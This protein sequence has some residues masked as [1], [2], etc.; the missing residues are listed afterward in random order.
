[1]PRKFPDT[2]ASSLVNGLPTRYILPY[3]SALILDGNAISVQADTARR[4][5][6][7][8]GPPVGAADAIFS[9]DPNTGVMAI[10]IECS[11][12]QARYRMK[13]S[14]MRG[15]RGAEVR[16][17][18]CG[19]TIAVLTPGTTSRA[20]VA[21]VPGGQSEGPRSHPLTEKDHSLVEQQ[22]PSSGRARKG[23]AAG[24]G[25]TQ[26]HTALAEETDATE[27]VPDNVY[28]LELVRGGRPKR[29]PTGGYDISGS[30]R[31]DPPT[32]ATARESA[33]RSPSVAEPLEELEGSKRLIL[34]EEPIHGQREGIASAP[35]KASLAAPD[36]TPDYEKSPANISRLPWRFSISTHH[37]P[38]HITIFY[39]LLLLLGGLG[40]LLV[41]FFS[42]MINGGGG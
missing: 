25:K 18:K 32:S 23:V 29:L 24:E 31:P 12:C 34:L 40:Y 2:P 3:T 20:P 27:P 15:F 11:C 9:S 19:G 35:A 6:I 1:M 28:P 39:L 8:Y 33:E 22:D 36:K 30:I 4:Y 16:C 37:R 38:T 7:L 26:T 21:K 17:R 41:R 5:G 14:M 10:E 13:T 42:Q